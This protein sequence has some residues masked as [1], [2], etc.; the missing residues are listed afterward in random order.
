MM[1]SVSYKKMRQVD[2]QVG[3]GQ[4]SMTK[5]CMQGEV[6]VLTSEMENVLM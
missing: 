3:C 5:K 2:T 6:I 4:G 1:L